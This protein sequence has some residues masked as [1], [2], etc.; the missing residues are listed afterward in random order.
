MSAGL[1][2]FNSF[3]MVCLFAG[4]PFFL[5]WLNEATFTGASL[6]LWTAGAAYVF[7]FFGMTGFVFKAVS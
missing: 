4:A 1:K 3:Q 2:L 6:A 5:S 7:S